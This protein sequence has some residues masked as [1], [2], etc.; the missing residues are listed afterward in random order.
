MH[1]DYLKAAYKDELVGRGIVREIIRL[2]AAGCF[3]FLVDPDNEARK[4]LH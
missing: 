1:P 2:T 4:H 3:G